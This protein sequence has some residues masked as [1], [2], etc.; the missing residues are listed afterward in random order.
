[1]SASVVGLGIENRELEKKRGRQSFL[2]ERESVGA[3]AP[4][5]PPARRFGV[6][7]HQTTECATPTSVAFVK[8][9]KSSGQVGRRK[10]TEQQGKRKVYG[11]RQ[12]K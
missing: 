3:G 9:A 1:M 4:V 2:R 5:A 10:G 11:S 8:L 6:Y 7:L 12:L